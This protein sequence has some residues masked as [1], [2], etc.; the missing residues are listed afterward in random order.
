MSENDW[1][2]TEG[3]LLSLLTAKLPDSF[4][5]GKLPY[6]FFFVNLMIALLLVYAYISPYLYAT[7]MFLSLAAFLVL[8]LMMVHFGLSLEWAVHLGSG[9]AA[10][11]LVYAI[12]VASLRGVYAIRVC[13]MAL[14]R[15]LA[16]G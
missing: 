12:W 2:K 9:A 13:T 3:G 10:V 16:G 6:L 4:K 8:L 15:P 11:L 1:P 7:P 5:E 14:K